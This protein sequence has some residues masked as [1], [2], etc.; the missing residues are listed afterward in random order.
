MSS[1]KLTLGKAIDLLLGALEPLDE[2]SRE[3]AII[4]ACRQLSIGVALG[5]P[6][7]Q[8]DPTHGGNE[9]SLAPPAN[10]TVTQRVDIRSLKEQKS[11]NSAKQMACVVAYYLR[12][13]ADAEERKDTVSTADLEKYFKQAGFKL[14]SRMAQVLVD[15][16]GAGYFESVGRGEY[17]LNAVGHNLVAH[18]LPSSD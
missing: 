17:K 6:T 11:P 10:P 18:N 14:Q 9:N 4:A 15:A 7:A 3:T 2:S 8:K 13:L 1:E 5:V 12:E 16:K